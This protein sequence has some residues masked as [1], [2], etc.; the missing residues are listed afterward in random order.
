MTMLATDDEIR[1]REY[2][3]C[4][5][6][7]HEARLE[8]AERAVELHRSLREGRMPR[9]GH[10]SCT[11]FR[12]R[13][14][15]RPELPAP[16]NAAELR[17]ACEAEAL[18]VTGQSPADDERARMVAFVAFGYT[19]AEGKWVRN[20]QLGSALAN[21]VLGYYT[22]GPKSW[23]QRELSTR[24]PELAQKARAFGQGLRAEWEVRT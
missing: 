6:L 23:V 22:P 21:R 10:V 2:A 13:N 19:V 5:A 9:D 12:A 14:P 20:G 7:T 1:A 11:T 16:S 8:Q 24:W 4:G 18:R 15:G 3:T 17:A